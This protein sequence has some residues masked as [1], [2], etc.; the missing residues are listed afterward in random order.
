[1]YCFTMIQM[2][3]ARVFETK[4][5]CDYCDHNR[6]NSINNNSIGGV[7]GNKNS[8]NFDKTTKYNKNNNNTN[9]N[10]NTNMIK[11]VKK[12]NQKMKLINH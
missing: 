8:L 4:L 11:S 9:T 10:S 6:R 1:M 12:L 5:V 3:Y 2:I 7:G